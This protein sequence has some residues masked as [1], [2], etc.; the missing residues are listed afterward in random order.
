MSSGPAAT[1]QAPAPEQ[2]KSGL[3]ILL[4]VLGIFFAFVLICVI[5]FVVVA[6]MFIHKAKETV[7]LGNK[8]PIYAGAK[9]AASLNPDVTIVCGPVERDPESKES[10]VNPTAVVE[11]LS[12][13]TISPWRSSSAFTAD[14]ARS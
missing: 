9:L 6:G 8:N 14:G 11:V 5:G 1:P 2:K 4:W 7:E 10:V 3:K 12:P 13:S